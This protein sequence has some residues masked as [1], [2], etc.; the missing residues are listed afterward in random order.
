M[1]TTQNTYT[2]V[3]YKHMERYKCHAEERAMERGR[4]LRYDNIGKTLMLLRKK[5]WNKYHVAL[6][7]ISGDATLDAMSKMVDALQKFNTPQTNDLAE[8]IFLAI[9]N[10][11]K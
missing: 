8:K 9:K 7:D 5:A 11:Q 10:Y 2:G 3:N 1:E 6:Q 4:P